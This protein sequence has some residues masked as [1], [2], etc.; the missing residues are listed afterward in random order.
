MMSALMLICGS[1]FAEDIIWAE[2]WSGVTEFKVNPSGFQSNYSFTGFQLNDDQSFKSGTTFYNEALAGGEAPELLIAKNGGSFTVSPLPLGDRSGDMF[3]SF[4][5]NKKLTVTVEGATLGEATNAGNDYVYPLTVEEGQAH[6]SITFTMETSANARLDNIKLYQ[7]TAKKPA[8]LSWGKASTTVTLGSTDNLPELQNS[9]NLFVTFT[10]S[11]TDVATIDEQGTI[12]L[13]SVGKTVLTAAF[14]GN[15]EYEAQ[16]VSIEMTVREGTPDN[17][18]PQTETI[19]VARALEII[20]ALEDGKT[21]EETYQIK[22]YVVS[23]TEIST[24][25]GNATFTIADEKGGQNVLTVF[26][27]KGFN[28]ANITDENILKVDDEVV[29]EG[30]LQKYVK[31]GNM[32]PEVAQGGKIISINGQTGGETPPEPQAEQVTVAKALEIIDA[33]ENGKTT[34]ETYRVK[35]Y[36]V[37]VTEISMQYGN[38][39]FTIA[40]EQG[41]Q[42]VLTVFRAKGFDGENI[43]DENLLKVDDEVIVEGKLQKYVKNENVTPEV[44]Q[45]GKIISI[46][47]QGSANI[48]NIE[49]NA[50]QGRIYNLQGQRVDKAVRGLYIIDGK[51]MLVK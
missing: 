3:L 40:D 15:D 26:R 4:K 6:I 34:T 46:N 23:V 37:S 51:K 5:S 42:N 18:D 36:V 50:Q 28:G 31:D 25:Y 22:G 16:S 33:L 44:A 8:G 30:K 48:S 24:Q 27:S 47:G 14:E 49:Y 10:S 19:T 12:D 38:A 41:G 1:A 35:G 13:L 7:G 20:N 43:T 9:N 45:G 21:T 39:T 11:N 29:V 17:P 2:D 32:T